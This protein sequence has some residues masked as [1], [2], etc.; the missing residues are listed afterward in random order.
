MNSFTKH[1]RNDKLPRGRV[2]WLSGV[3]ERVMW[4]E[5]KEAALESSFVMMDSSDLIVAV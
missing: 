1:S 4:C 5:Y 3:R 2:E